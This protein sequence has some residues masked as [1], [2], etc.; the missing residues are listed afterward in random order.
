MSHPELPRDVVANTDVLY[1]R[2]HSVPELYKSPYSV[3]ELRQLLEQIRAAEHVREAYIYFNNDID[4]SA[5]LNAK[6]LQELYQQP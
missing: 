3:E 1:Y 2:L 5:I 4:A 6:Q